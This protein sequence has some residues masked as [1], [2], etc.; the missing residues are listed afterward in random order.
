ML[1]I[2]TTQLTGVFKKIVEDEAFSLEDGA[3]LLAQAGAGSG[4][5][6]IFGSREMKAIEFEAL[7]GAEP[8][9]DAVILTKSTIEDLTD[10]DRVLLISRFATDEEVNELAILLQEK[11]IPFVLIS[12]V[13]DEEADCPAVNLADVHINLRLTKGLIPDEFGN[14]F[15]YPASMAALFAYY[16]IKFSI[17]EMLS[18]YE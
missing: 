13:L 1:K 11:G 7:E 2:F 14:R 4:T 8:L 15:G 3:R 16:G 17:D 9:K 12:T 10:A 6:Y 18:E 5:I